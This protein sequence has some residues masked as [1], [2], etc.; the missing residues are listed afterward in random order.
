MRNIVAKIGIKLIED[1]QNAFSKYFNNKVNLDGGALICIWLYY[2]ELE[3][4][5]ENPNNIFY[6][7]PFRT[8]IDDRFFILSLSGIRS[9]A[10]KEVSGHDMTYE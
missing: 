2:F 10:L 1:L 7:N 4:G 5:L 9:T 8:A 3:K 6:E